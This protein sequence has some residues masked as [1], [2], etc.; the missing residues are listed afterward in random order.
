MQQKIYDITPTLSDT[1]PVWPGDPK[2]EFKRVLKLENGDIANLTH[3]KMCAHTGTHIDAPY[4]FLKDG[5]TVENLPL[6]ILIGEAVVIE[7]P[8]ENSIS[9]EVLR[10]VEIPADTKRLLFKTRNSKEWVS[11]S[12]E[13]TEEYV[14]ITADGAEYLVEKGIKLIGVDYLSVAPFNDLV[15]THE[16]LLKAGIIIVEGLNLSEV[17]GGHYTLYCLP[18]KI[19]HADGAPARAI[20]V[21]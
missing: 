2:P 6:E 10:L 20:L 17:Q 7:L 15:P 13:F 1:I 5:D 21:Q 4:H 18:L 14:A 12:T 9:A 16:I 11:G 3:M 19:A 8:E